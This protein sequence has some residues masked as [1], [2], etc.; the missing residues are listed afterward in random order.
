MPEKGGPVIYYY[1]VFNKGVRAIS[2]VTLTDNKCAA[3]TFTGGDINGDNKLDT[4][5]VWTYICKSN[6]TKTTTNTGTVRGQV[7]GRYATDTDDAIVRVE[8]V[9]GTIP[10]IPKEMPKTG[11][12][13]DAIAVNNNWQQTLF[14]IFVLLV[15]MASKLLYKRKC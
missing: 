3:V 1:E 5:E 6:I 15:V 9:K 4:D 11:R 14:I 7:D 12:G 2:D 8:R 10:K 13:E